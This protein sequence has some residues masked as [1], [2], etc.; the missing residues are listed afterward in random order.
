MSDGS[1]RIL[2]TQG[3]RVQEKDGSTRMEGI[4]QD[5]T[6]RKQVEEQV[7]TLA[8][9][10]GLTGLGNRRF[11]AESLQSAVSL[12]QQNLTPLAVLFLD[13]DDF[14]VVNDT[15]GH[16]VGDQLLC[17][18]AD[19][20][21]PS[22]P[23]PARWALAF[24]LIG[25]I[26]DLEVGLYAY[27]VIVTRTIKF[28]IL[29]LI[30]WVLVAA[31]RDSVLG[32][33]LGWSVEQPS[34]ARWKSAAVAGSVWGAYRIV[35]ILVGGPALGLPVVAYGSAELLVQITVSLM[36]AAALIGWTFAGRLRYAVETRVAPEQPVQEPE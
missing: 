22:V 32:L 10:D 25:L 24:G 28:P 18:V 27:I 13:L 16:T 21:I 9:R 23:R 8:Y 36:L 7:R 15:L 6:E 29:M 3:E 35:A 4:V 17:V 19:R 31:L 14:K 34:G 12:A 26:P 11:F 30:V 20:L 5:V 33:I 2:H 1:D